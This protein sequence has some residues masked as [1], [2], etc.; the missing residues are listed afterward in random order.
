MGPT[1]ISRARHWFR[2]PVTGF[3]GPTLVSWARHCFRGPDTVFV[4]PTQISWARHCFRGPDTD[5]MGPTP[6]IWALAREVGVGP[7]KPVSGPYIQCRGKIG[8][9]FYG[10]AHEISVGPTKTV[11]GPRNRCRAHE[12]VTEKYTKI[13]IWACY[14]WNFGKRKTSRCSYTLGVSFS[15]KKTCNFTVPLSYKG[16]LFSQIENASTVISYVYL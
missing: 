11:S 9:I 3:V 8:E 13:D 2:G 1:P 12:N 4:G 15:A 7:T 5:F 6:L 16:M 14:R 10:Q